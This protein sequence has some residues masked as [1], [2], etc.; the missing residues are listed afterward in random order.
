MTGNLC[1]YITIY[2]WQI[3]VIV[4]YHIFLS[5]G[6]VIFFFKKSDILYIS[7]ATHVASGKLVFRFMVRVGV[8]FFYKR[9]C[10]YGFK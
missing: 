7:S 6:I 5:G 9:M 10:Y 4:V 1:I 8:L 2:V 3:N